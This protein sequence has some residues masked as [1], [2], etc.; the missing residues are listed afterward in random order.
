MKFSNLKSLYNDLL[1]IGFTNEEIREFIEN[2]GEEQEDF[3][4]DEIRVIS[5]DYIGEVL[6]NEL[7]QDPYILGCFNDWFIAKHSDLSIDIV[8]AL[9]EADKYEV[10]G[11]HLIDNDN[12]EDLASAYASADGYG[13]YFNSYD[14]REEEIKVNDKWYHVFLN[15]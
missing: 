10:I 7:S 11:K 3:S 2:I 4:I 14:Y 12:V 5:K 6:E 15:R 9:Q 8:K 1:N 13:D